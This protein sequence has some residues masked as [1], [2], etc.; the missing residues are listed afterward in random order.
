MAVSPALRP[1]LIGFEA[2][3]HTLRVPHYD[4]LLS[5]DF[6][7]FR[8]TEPDNGPPLFIDCFDRSRW[9]ERRNYTVLQTRFDGGQ[10]F[11]SAWSAWRDDPKRCERLHFVAVGALESL[12]SPA[13]H[14]YDLGLAEQLSDAWPMQVAG[15]HRLEFEGGHVVLT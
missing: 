8:M 5:V 13:V 9:A 7:N 11:L 10:L 4:A 2:D 3:W 15:V 12:K 6:K 14:S 1:A